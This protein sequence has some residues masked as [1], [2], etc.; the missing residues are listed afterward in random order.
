MP[1]S[2]MTRRGRALV[3]LDEAE[4]DDN[5]AAEGGSKKVKME[6]VEMNGFDDDEEEDYKPKLDRD[7]EE[8]N[9]KKRKKEPS[10]VS[11]FLSSSSSQLFV[12][13]RLPSNNNRTQNPPKIQKVLDIEGDSEGGVS[14]DMNQH[15]TLTFSLKYLADAVRY[16]IDRDE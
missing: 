1:C 3:R 5:D 7:K 16:H 15:V 2:R 8:S 11:P 13:T 10:K 4:G 14:I 12:L 6:D 9:N